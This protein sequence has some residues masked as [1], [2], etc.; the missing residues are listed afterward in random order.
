[1]MENLLYIHVLSN[2][3]EIVMPDRINECEGVGRMGAYKMMM[4]IV[5]PSLIYISRHYPHCG[6]S[7]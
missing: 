7:L 3:D 1:M 6:V 5:L 4:C 2:T